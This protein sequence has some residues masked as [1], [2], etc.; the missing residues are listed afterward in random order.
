MLKSLRA[1]S[2]IACVVLLT[3]PVMANWPTDAASPLLVG[4]VF[5]FGT[6]HAAVSTPDG[7]TWVAWIDSGCFPSLFVQRISAEG[8]GLEGGPLVL[9]TQDGCISLS[10]R[11]ESF[12][13]NTV[14]VTAIGNDPLSNPVHRIAAD[15][16]E[17]W[18]PQVVADDVGAG[19]VHMLRSMLD[20]DALVAS[21]VGTSVVVGRY[22]ADGSRAWNPPVVFTT[23][24]GSNMRIFAVE[25]DGANGTY[26]L[27]DSPGT[28]TR[29]IYAMRIAADGVQAWEAPTLMINIPPGSSRHTDPV[30]MADG[31]GGLVLV[32]TQGAEQGNTPV[33]LRMQ[34]L[35]PD[36]TMFFDMS[37]SRISTSGSRQF[38]AQIRQRVPGG[39]VYV[40]WRNGPFDNQEVRAQR[41]TLNGQRAW[42]DEG[43]LVAPLVSSASAFSFDWLNAD[44]LGIAVTKTLV[45]SNDS[46]VRLHRVG[47]TGILEPEGWPISDSTPA[48]SVATA[49]LEGALAVVWL[50]DGDSN[51]NE[52]VAQR[53]NDNGTLGVVDTD[54]DGVSDVADNCT[55]VANSSQTDTDADGI[56]NSC[57]PDF[58]NDCAVN[59]I[60]Y[61]EL[62]EA[63]LSTASPLYD[64]NSDGVVNFID[65][66]I[67]QSFFLLPP[68]PSG[69]AGECGS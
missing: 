69:L 24:G 39:D 42:A 51:L 31:L 35:L 32:W 6:E 25:P 1:Y 11:L 29:R 20:G 44:T 46:S 15:G 65:V 41:M 36:G 13:D 23:G 2:L 22:T 40:V 66:S 64:L 19:N 27:W 53:I 4:E 54:G 8:T 45:D 10:V 60:D 68:G 5:S 56:G 7:A 55:A 3:T 9:D 62:T 43:L 67:F 49:A 17:L 48:R 38:D 52:F 18:L 50:R 21:Q 33:P 57:D 58:N 34:R 30:A 47:K 16:E 59:F 12:V 26:V 28:Y 63:F 37:G 14:V 61:V